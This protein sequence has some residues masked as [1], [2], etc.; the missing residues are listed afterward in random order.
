VVKE[1]L[2]QIK[3]NPTKEVGVITFNAP[4][5]MLIM[6]LVEEVF[7]KES[8]RV[9][10]TLF[11]KNIE[12]VQG[13]ERD[14]IIFSI[15]YAPDE[16]GK[17]NM[18]FGSLNTSGGENRLNV[19]VTRAREKVIV[20]SSIVPEELKIDAIK[21]D[22][23]KLLRKY[24]EYARD[25]SMGKSNYQLSAKHQYSSTW[26]LSSK[27][28]EGKITQSNTEVI[29]SPLP[30]SDLAIKHTTKLV[31]LILVDDEL[32]YSSL[33]IK[34]P[35]AYTPLLLSQKHW[36][37]LRVYSRNWWIDQD[38]TRFELNKFVYQLTS[39]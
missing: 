13:D 31:G 20:I 36:K 3:S 12:N 5:Q 11:V 33:T 1:L 18:H 27:L 29:P 24:L 16:K 19:A 23:P 32:F 7:A 25:V 15:G 17:L 39:V 2:N 21:N 22:G 28:L 30:F 26:Y 34:E 6:D 38:K 4:Q 35:F 9:P 14:T 37:F 8:I 10:E